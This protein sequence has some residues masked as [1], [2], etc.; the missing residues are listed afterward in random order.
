MYERNVIRDHCL[1]PD[2]SIVSSGAKLHTSSSNLTPSPQSRTYF[3]LRR[4][5]M[6]FISPSGQAGAIYSAERQVSA[7]DCQISSAWLPEKAI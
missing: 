1:F 7:L 6:H 5:L 4:P 2:T 3:Y